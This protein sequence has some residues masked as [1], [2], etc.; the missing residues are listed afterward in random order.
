MQESARA[1]GAEAA[2]LFQGLASFAQQRAREL[3]LERLYFVTREGT[4]YRQV[5]DALFPPEAKAPAVPSALVEASRQATFGP[6]VHQSGPVGLERLWNL[7]PR[8]SPEAF[9]KSLNLEP[10]RFRAYFA[11]AGLEPQ[12]IVEHPG[13]DSRFQRVLRNPEFITE[14]QRS[15]ERD[16]AL[17]RSYFERAFEG[18][19]RIG[20]LEIGWQGS[21]QDNLA[22]LFPERRF[23]GFYL[24]L[25]VAKNAPVGN[26]EKQAFGPDRNR[27]TAHRSLLNAVNVL[28]FMSLT[29]GGS[30]TRYVAGAGGQAVA[31]RALNAQE[32]EHIRRFSEPFQQGVISGCSPERAPGLL[33]GL[34]SGETR[35]AALDAWHRILDDPDP[36]LVESYFALKSNEEFGMGEF[37][38]QSS[39]PSWGTL[40]KA[41]LDSGSRRALI[42][43]LTYSQ[44]A[45]GMRRRRDLPFVKRWTL[46]FLV[47]TAIA[48]KAIQHGRLRRQNAS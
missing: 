33:A 26:S 39:T 40:L 7:Y 19:S 47:R 41:P 32:D 36:A 23:F 46:Y 2:A 3:G 37:R 13:A 22:L 24:G 18:Q 43:Y 38:N 44:W 25:A 29:R 42:R 21:I 12:S 45:Q 27:S 6:A 35:Q 48:A 8:L 15:L 16:C 11:H 9:L 30:V 10:G 5:H 4:F 28:E 31:E 34:K 14:S 1:L 17:A 20:L